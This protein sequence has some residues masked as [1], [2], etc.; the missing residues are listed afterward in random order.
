MATTV[1]NDAD[2]TESRPNCRTKARVSWRDA[3]A[4]T[5][6]ITAW[7]RGVAAGFADHTGDDRGTGPGARVGGQ[8]GSGSV[9]PC[10]DPYGL[11]DEARHERRSRHLISAT[12]MI[13]RTDL[14]M[15][16]HRNMAALPLQCLSG[17][18]E[19]CMIYCILWP[20]QLRSRWI[21]AIRSAH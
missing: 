16:A 5:P 17:Q 13:N 7:P 6:L 8:S 9:R 1:L 14:P 10:R 12:D 3:P 4:G 18:R 20:K 15:S 11:V 2:E 19:Y 21:C